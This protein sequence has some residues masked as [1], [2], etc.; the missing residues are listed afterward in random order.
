MPGSLACILSFGLT[1]A[2]ADVPVAEAPAATPLEP[3][4]PADPE[5]APTR[6]AASMV[7][8]QVQ[9]YY[10]ATKDLKADFTQTYVHPVYGTKKVSRGVLKVRKPGMMVWD[11]LADDDPDFWVDGSKVWVVEAPQ[12]Q[13]IAKDVGTSDIA[14]A[15]KFLFGGKQLTDDFKVK[16]AEAKL[17]KTYGMKG[18]TAVRLQPKKK[19][20]HYR[21]LM[22]VVDDASG[23]VDAFVVLNQDKSTNH[24]VLS[25]T[26][27]NAGMRSSELE[28]KKPSGYAQIEG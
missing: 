2:P 20:P 3:A 23:R 17:V 14:G 26:K 16:L 24:F 12:R 22:L 13:V 18:H 11:Y 9:S 1:C 19:S 10:D 25:G 15:E 28:F 6:G 5:P 8:A 4:A 21:E 27:R 7:L